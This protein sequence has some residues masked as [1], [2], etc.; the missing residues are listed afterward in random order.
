MDAS[1][2]ILAAFFPVQCRYSGLAFCMTFGAAI[3]GNNPNMAQFLK[4]YFDSILAPGF[5]LMVLSILT[6]IALIHVSRRNKT[7]T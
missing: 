2:L 5:L 7:Y 3:L 1:V 4:E 6:L